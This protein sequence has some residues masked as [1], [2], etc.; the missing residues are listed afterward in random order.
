MSYATNGVD[1][2]RIWFEDAG[3]DGAPVVVHGG[4]V[5]TV[6]LLRQGAIARALDGDEFRL[7]LVDHRGVGR[8]DAPHDVEA[9]AMPLRVGDVVAILDELGL[10][11]AHFI[12]TSYGARLGFG[13]G[14]HAPGRVRTLVMGGQQPYA[15]NPDGPLFKMLTTSLARSAEDGTMEPFVA[16]L[17]RSAGGRRRPDEI[18]SLYLQQDPKAVNAASSMMVAEG[19]VA[20]SLGSWRTPCLIFV[21]EEDED[22]VSQARRA[23]EEIPD[24]E[25]VLVP[26]LGHLGAHL[27][28][29]VVIPAILRTLRRG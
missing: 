25:F 28:H 1:A 7:I 27:S 11:R 2:V 22:F 15:L 12:G 19:V 26:A 16:A 6:S 4:L 13:L 10:A 21:G 29:D 17:E 23:A 8:S 18:R 20:R 24:A 5:D 9:Y 3:G 14:E